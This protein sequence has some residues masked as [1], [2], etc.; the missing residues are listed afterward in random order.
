MGL[1][2]AVVD[3]CCVEGVGGVF[4]GLDADDGGLVGGEEGGRVLAVGGGG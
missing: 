1:D 2:R 3:N 4:M